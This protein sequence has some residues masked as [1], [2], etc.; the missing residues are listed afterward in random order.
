MSVASSDRLRAGFRHPFLLAA[1]VGLAILATLWVSGNLG[2]WKGSGG[3]FVEFE[4][5]LPPGI[6][7]PPDRNI[8]VTFWSDGIGRDCRRIEVWRSTDPPEIVGKCSLIGLDREAALSVRFSRFAEGFWKVPVESPASRDPDF[9]P[10]QRID[11]TWAPVGKRVVSSL[12]HG[13]YYFRYL[14]RP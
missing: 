11:F 6:L 4:I 7:L 3:P 12:P 10:W 14:V 13:E 8:E 1:A 5:R 2:R 9:G